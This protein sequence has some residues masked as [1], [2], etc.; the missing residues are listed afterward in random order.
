MLSRQFRKDIKSADDAN[1]LIRLNDDNSMNVVLN[2]LSDD[3]FE[4][5]RWSTRHDVRAMTSSTFMLGIWPRKDRL[6]GTPSSSWSSP[7]IIGPS[8]CISLAT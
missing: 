8:D 2:H 7:V 5:R 4:W 1:R 3:F 6:S